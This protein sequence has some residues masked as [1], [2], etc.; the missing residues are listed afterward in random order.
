[1][2]NVTLI[3]RGARDYTFTTTDEEFEDNYQ[4]MLVDA[5]EEANID[6][7]DIINVTSEYEPDEDEEEEETSDLEE[8]FS[9]GDEVILSDEAREN[10]CYSKFLDSVL[11]IT[12]I[13]RST[14][15]HPGFDTGAGSALYDLNF[16]DSG[17]PCP[18][19]LYDWE[20]ELA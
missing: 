16:K 9:I 17:D 13:S 19:S 8:N 12:G 14:A 20:L 11:V 5:C 3:I 1:M 7:D 18:N 10:D 6:P 4:S 2:Y 15:D